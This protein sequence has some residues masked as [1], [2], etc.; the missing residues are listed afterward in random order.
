VVN[1]MGSEVAPIEV[2]GAQIAEGE[3]GD[4]FGHVKDALAAIPN[5]MKLMSSGD[6]T[7]LPHAGL[8]GIRHFRQERIFPSVVELGRGHRTVGLFEGRMVIVPVDSSRFVLQ[9]S[10]HG[11]DVLLV[12]V[13]VDRLR[14]LPVESLADRALSIEEQEA[15]YFIEEGAASDVSIPR[16]LPKGD[17]SFPFPDGMREVAEIFVLYPSTHP[18]AHDRFQILR[19]EPGRGRITII[20]ASD[21]LQPMNDK[22]RSAARLFRDPKT[23]RVIGDCVRAQPFVLTPDLSRVHVWLD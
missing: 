16:D 20:P 8:L 7:P 23:D 19:A 15:A 10:V 9:R 18:D 4:C 6:F 1:L 12:C 13:T 17:H 11:P 3:I 14:P 2:D 22:S 21:S 5:P